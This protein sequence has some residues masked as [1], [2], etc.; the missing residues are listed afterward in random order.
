M[1]KPI[2]NEKLYEDA[3]KR[4]ESLWGS[5][6][7]TPEGDELDILITLVEAYED[8]H[9]PMPPSDPV[10]AILFRMDQLDLGRKDLERFIGPKSRVSDV[11]KRKRPLSLKQIVRLHRGMDIPYES[12]IDDSRIAE[13]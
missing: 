5:E 2:R 8:K 3:L 12:L 10:E 1:I 9:Y 13:G 6:P 7:G 11:L 4:I